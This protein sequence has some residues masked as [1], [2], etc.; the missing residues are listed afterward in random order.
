MIG[1]TCTHTWFMSSGSFGGRRA[2]PVPADAFDAVGDGA[3]DLRQRTD[4]VVV[5]ADD[6][7]LA[8]LGQG[9][10]PLVG[11]VVLPTQW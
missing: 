2:R 4:P 9:D 7:E 1:Q 10:E 6:G 8:D 5:V 11:R 3:L